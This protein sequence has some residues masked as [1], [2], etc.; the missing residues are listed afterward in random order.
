MIPNGP[1]HPVGA[2]LATALST[3]LPAAPTG[4]LSKGITYAVEELVDST[5]HWRA[6]L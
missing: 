1:D 5:M 2:I 6:I 4:I 3:I